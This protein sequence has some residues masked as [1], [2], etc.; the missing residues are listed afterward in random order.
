MGQLATSCDLYSLHVT[1]GRRFGVTAFRPTYRLHAGKLLCFFIICFLCSPHIIQH[2]HTHTHTH[3]HTLCMLHLAIENDM[4]ITLELDHISSIP[5][6][7]ERESLSLEPK[8]LSSSLLH[9]YQPCHPIERIF[10]SF[11][12]LIHNWPLWDMSEVMQT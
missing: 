5:H 11:I 8:T 12:S 9:F 10:I 6:C 7:R 4:S 3:T 1:H 2:Q